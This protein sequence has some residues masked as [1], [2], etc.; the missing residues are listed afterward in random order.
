MKTDEFLGL[1]T[2]ELGQKAVVVQRGVG[3]NTG[4]PRWCHFSHADHESMANCI[5]GLKDKHIY[6]AL[7]GFKDGAITEFQGRNQENVA[8]LRSLWMDIDVGKDDP[9]K[10]P[11]KRAAGAAIGAFLESTGLPEP[12]VVVSGGGLHIYW[13]LVADVTRTA[14]KPVA[15]A[16][17]AEALKFG[18]LVDHSRTCDEASIM[19]PIGTFNNKIDDKPREVVAL[20]WAGQP[21]SIGTLANLLGS[22]ASGAV[23][24]NALHFDPADVACI[25]VEGIPAI[26]LDIGSKVSVLSVQKIADMGKLVDEKSAG[27]Y[28][29]SKGEPAQSGYQLWLKSVLMPLKHEAAKRPA[30]AA[31]IKDIFDAVSA[32][33]DAVGGTESNLALWNSTNADRTSIGT[34]IAIARH[35]GY[36]SREAEDTET[37]A[38]ISFF[39]ERYAFVDVAGKAVIVGSRFD[40]EFGFHRRTYARPQQFKE[41]Y[42]EPFEHHDSEGRRK[43]TTRGE[44]WLRSSLK[45]RYNNIAFLPNQTAPDDT[46]NLWRGFTVEPEKGDCSLLLTHILDN[47]CDGDEHKYKRVTQFMAHTVQYPSVKPGYIVVLIGDEGTG[48]GVFVNSF[49]SLFGS[50]YCSSLDEKALV[51]QF[52]GE[53]EE[54]VVCF[55]DE[56]TLTDKSN[57]TERFKKL[58]TEKVIRLEKKGIDAIEVR[59][60]HRYFLATNNAHAVPADK[61]AR[62]YFVLRVGTNVMQH[63]GYFKNLIGQLDSGGREALLHYLMYEV[64]VSDFDPQTAPVTAELAEQKRM[65]LSPIESWLADQLA[66]GTRWHDPENA[67]EVQTTYLVEEIRAATGERETAQSIGRALGRLFR[68]ATKKQVTMSL[69]SGRTWHW[70]LPKLELARQEFCAATGATLDYQG[71]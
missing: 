62:R 23:K 32:R 56:V 40:S 69:G 48:K 68:S 16:L 14:W 13:P 31:F 53:M 18:L 43:M 27:D 15:T 57:S 1:V 19:R 59:S 36:G 71:Q 46:Y 50:H 5:Q 25:A 24:Q 4:Q 42:A 51:G 2:S 21:T 28:F 30:D 3:T 63:T 70:V 52:N 41:L 22:A 10:Y 61:N 64:D 11:S 65:N 33:F 49:G 8:Y 47:I 6:F 35:A 17:K 54:A 34:F 9:K 38:L 60:Y 58:I 37:T 7:G 39:N 20:D 45:R 12:L 66:A 67:I 44:Y 26:S 55:A 29:N